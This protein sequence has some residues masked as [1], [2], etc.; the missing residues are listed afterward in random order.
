MR[1]LREISINTSQIYFWVFF[2]TLAPPLRLALEGSRRIYPD[3][4]GAVSPV[5]VSFEIVI[6]VCALVSLSEKL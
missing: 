5:N 3:G 6:L 1:V 2:C 4:R